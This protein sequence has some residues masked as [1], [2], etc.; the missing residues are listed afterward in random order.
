MAPAALSHG[1]RPGSPCLVA[2]FVPPAFLNAEASGTPGPCRMAG[3]PAAPE[4]VLSSSPL[5]LPLVP[6]RKHWPQRL[7][8]GAPCRSPRGRQG[9]LVSPVAA[10]PRTPHASGCSKRFVCPR[11]CAMWDLGGAQPGRPPAPR[12]LSCVTEL[13]S[14]GGKA[15]TWPLGALASGLSPPRG[16]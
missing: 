13:D 8:L 6:P 3:L 15:S 14:A 5:C 9:P 4:Q 2:A 16:I 1:N 11:C 10:Q 7:R 12:L